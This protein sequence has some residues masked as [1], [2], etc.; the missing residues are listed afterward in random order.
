MDKFTAFL[1]KLPNKPYALK[2]DD[3]DMLLAIA[4]HSVE[5]DKTSGSYI[6]TLENGE[7]YNDPDKPEDDYIKAQKDFYA[8]ADQLPDVGGCE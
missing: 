5:L 3:Y 6:Y 7:D 2:C 4:R 8:I 1:D